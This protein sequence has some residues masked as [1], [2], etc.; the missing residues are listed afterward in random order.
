MKTRKIE[1]KFN[2]SAIT[3]FVL[4]I[5]STALCIFVIPPLATFIYGIYT[6]INI[7]GNK[8]R[9]VILTILGIIISFLLIISGIRTWF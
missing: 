3:V 1:K 4:S 8:E 7:R 5:L 6:L 2:R 9:G